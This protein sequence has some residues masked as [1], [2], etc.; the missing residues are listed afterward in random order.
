MVS[1]LRGVFFTLPRRP[2]APDHP[3]TLPQ[4]NLFL[5]TSSADW[6]VSAVKVKRL[7][8]RGVLYRH[9]SVVAGTST[10]FRRMKPGVHGGS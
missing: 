1:P 9:G 7:E 10:S 5:G 3:A 6:I 8:K 4:P 2:F